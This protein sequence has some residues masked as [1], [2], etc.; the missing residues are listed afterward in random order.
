LWI[1]NGDPTEVTPA[2]TGTGKLRV[3][4]DQVQAEILLDGRRIGAGRVVD[5]TIPAGKT[6]ILPRVVLKAA[7]GS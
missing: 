1:A 6:E 3:A 4:A 7:G 5:Q 2:V